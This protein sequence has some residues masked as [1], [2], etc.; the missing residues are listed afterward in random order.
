[1]DLY[2]SEYGHWSLLWSSSYPKVNG[3]MLV[4]AALFCAPAGYLG[5]RIFDLHRSYKL[6]SELNSLLA[7]LGMIAL[8]FAP[9]PEP[10]EAEMA[11]NERLESGGETPKKLAG[12]L[13]FE[14]R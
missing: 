12:R 11:L 1:M 4:L 7:A 5:G 13:G 10:P 8:F 3:M 14:P 2:L 9:M 6:A